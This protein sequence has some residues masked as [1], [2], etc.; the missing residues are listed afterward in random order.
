[1]DYSTIDYDGRK[2]YK[3][4]RYCHLCDKECCSRDFFWCDNCTPKNRAEQRLFNS[5]SFK[6][7]S[8][9]NQLKELIAFRKR[10]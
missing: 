8:K 10:A 5:T 1:M 7:K 3:T 4:K 9:E 6:R 2:K